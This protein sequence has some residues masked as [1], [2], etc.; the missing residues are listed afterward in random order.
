MVLTAI[1]A[2]GGSA[3]ADV[4]LG[5]FDFN[6]SQFGNT[7]AQSDGGTFANNNWLNTVNANPGSPGYLTGANFNTGIA[8]IGFGGNMPNYT[9]GYST[10]ITNGTGTDLGVVTARFSTGDSITLA[11][12]TDGG[13]TFSAP[14]VFGPGLATNTGV[15]R[16]YFYNGFGGNQANLFVTPIDLAAFGLAAGA[17]VNAI[18]VTG[19]PELDL[20]R[21]AGFQRAAQQA[22]PEPLSVAV[23][24]GLT[25]VGGLMARRR[26]TKVA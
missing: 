12:S 3:R 13:V 1:L 9:I 18:R 8:N 22:V 7:L 6:S 21:V 5:T 20:I 16:N 24:G 14:Q 25:V 26:M 10:A 19:A 2:V 17:N 23:F 15:S 4:I 11:V